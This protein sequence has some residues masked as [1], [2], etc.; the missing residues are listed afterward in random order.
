MFD[1]AGEDILHRQQG[2]VGDELYIYTYTYMY[3]YMRTC[4]VCLTS[5]TGGIP[6]GCARQDLLH[7]Q[8]GPARDESVQ[9]GR[10]V[11]SS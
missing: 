9:T 7:R 1:I 3:I 4:V 2:S 5:T 6:T 8:Q 10:R 11:G